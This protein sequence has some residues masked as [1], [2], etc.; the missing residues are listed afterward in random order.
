MKIKSEEIHI[1]LCRTMDSPR[2]DTFHIFTVV[3]SSE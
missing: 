2:F 3:R 1:A